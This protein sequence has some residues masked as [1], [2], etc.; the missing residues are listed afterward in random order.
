MRGQTNSCK[1]VSEGVEKL[2]N[3]WERKQIVLL[4]FLC[5]VILVFYGRIHDYL[6]E[7]RFYIVGIN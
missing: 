1:R 3:I 6:F 5:R 4:S 7:V 2:E